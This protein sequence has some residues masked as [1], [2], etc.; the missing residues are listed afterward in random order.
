M[1]RVLQGRCAAIYLVLRDMSH[2]GPRYKSLAFDIILFNTTSNVQHVYLGP[3]HTK[4]LPG[5]LSLNAVARERK[6]LSV[7]L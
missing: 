7:I 3:L 5:G 2:T 4:A 1:W 6:S